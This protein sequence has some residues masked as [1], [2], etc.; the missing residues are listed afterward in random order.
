MTYVN[1]K[2][3][4]YRND[5]SLVKYAIGTTI[6]TMV[7]FDKEGNRSLFAF[8]KNGSQSRKQFEEILKILPNVK[9]IYSDSA[10]WY[11]N[12]EM[13]LL[14]IL[15]KSGLNYKKSLDLIPEWICGK[16][17]ETNIIEG[18]N[19]ALRNGVSSIKRR[20]SGCSKSLERL[21][22]LLNLTCNKINLTN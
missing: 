4:V 9:K 11:Q 13:Y 6:W 15:R 8:A 20:T 2:K 14:E 10:I 12:A 7:F 21:Q 18:F 17:S 19:N 22:I 3:F 5:G 16:G 1:H